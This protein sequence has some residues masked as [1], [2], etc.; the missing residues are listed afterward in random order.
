MGSTNGNGAGVKKGLVAISQS[1]FTRP[2]AEEAGRILH[3]AGYEIAPLMADQLALEKDALEELQA[4]RTLVGLL[5]ISLAEMADGLLNGL[6]REQ[7]TRLD[8]IAPTGLPVVVAPGDLDAARYAAPESVPPQFA[9][10]QLHPAAPDRHLMRVDVSDSARLGRLL[11]EKLNACVGPAAVCLPLRGLSALSAPGEPLRYMEAD[12]ALF[13][14]LTTH[15]RRDIR[16][17]DSNANINDPGFA[18]LCVET[19]LALKEPVKE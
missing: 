15:L 11:A 10:R 2:C 1:A 7:L 12:M 6:L 16:L 18:R 8:R 17:H 9:R 19:F 3:E 14:N 4:S 5:E 13:G